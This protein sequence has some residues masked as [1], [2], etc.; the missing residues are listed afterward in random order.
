MRQ[1][2]TK[3]FS[4]F[5]FQNKGNEMASFHFLSTSDIPM[6]KFSPTYI[7]INLPFPYKMGI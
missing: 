1:I 5:I 2:E 4:K 3:S 7:G 6:N